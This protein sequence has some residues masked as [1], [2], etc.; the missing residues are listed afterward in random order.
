MR[1][2]GLIGL[3]PEYDTANWSL[4]V[5]RKPGDTLL[6]TIKDIR[7]LPKTE[8]VFDFK[9][10]E[11]WSQVSYWGEFVSAIFVKHY[12]LTDQ[13]RLAYAGLS[14]PDNKYY[15]GID[16]KSMMHPRP[17]SVMK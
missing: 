11:G 8:I 6:L 5:I 16:M 2:N 13:A 10:I 3:Q 9:C 4:Q 1:V 15:V 17:C 12:G 14:T 7:S